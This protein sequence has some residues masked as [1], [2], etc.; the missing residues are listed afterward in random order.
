[1]FFYHYQN[2]K[3]FLIFNHCN[4]KVNLYMSELPRSRGWKDDSAIKSTDCFC[5]GPEFNSCIPFRWVTTSSRRI[6]YLWPSWAPALTG[7]NLYT[8]THTH[9]KLKI[10]KSLNWKKSTILGAKGL[11]MYVAKLLLIFPRNNK[12]KLLF[13]D[14][15]LFFWPLF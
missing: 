11:N 15:G 6:W 8:D 14:Y 4:V 5:R 2:F 12:S 13:K 10:I 1:M 9:A 7:S 3:L